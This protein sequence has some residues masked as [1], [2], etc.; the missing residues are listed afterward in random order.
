MCYLCPAKFMTSVCCLSA[1]SY[2]VQ[3]HHCSGHGNIYNDWKHPLRAS[4]SGL[5]N[6]HKVCTLWGRLC[7]NLTLW[8]MRPLDGRK[9]LQHWASSRCFSAQ[10][11]NRFHL[12]HDCHARPTKARVGMYQH[13]LWVAQMGTNTFDHGRALAWKVVFSPTWLDF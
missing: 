12:S 1:L 6:R 9:I 4:E 11:C 2:L 3:W 10:W 7:L 13:T 5:C 8:F